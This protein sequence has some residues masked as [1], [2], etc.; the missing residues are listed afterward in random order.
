MGNDSHYDHLNPEQKLM[1]VMQMASK[2]GL[3]MI[4][5][6]VSKCVIRC[7]ECH[8]PVTARQRRERRHRDQLLQIVAEKLREQGFAF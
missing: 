6:E 1:S 8:K 2:Y 4:L 7:Y 3:A 5:S